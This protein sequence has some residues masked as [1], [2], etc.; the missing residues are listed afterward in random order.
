VSG[1]G[2]SGTAPRARAAASAPARCCRPYCP[3]RHRRAP[4]P[5]ARHTPPATRIVKTSRL[6][7]PTASAS[8]RCSGRRWRRRCATSR[9]PSRPTRKSYAACWLSL[10]RLRPRP[11]TKSTSPPSKRPSTSSCSSYL[12][13]RFLTIRAS[14]SSTLAT[15][16]SMLSP[17]VRLRTPSSALRRCCQL[18]AWRRASCAAAMRPRQPRWRRRCSGPAW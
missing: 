15:S 10:P 16:P 14:Q 11:V 6:R 4:L 7:R 2:S 3:P 18:P 13:L 5:H 17:A 1:S 8:N 9:P 12:R